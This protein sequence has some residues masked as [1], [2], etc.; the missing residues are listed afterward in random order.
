MSALYFVLMLL[1]ALGAGA[2][3][4]RAA[5]VIGRLARLEV[6]ALSFALGVGVVGWLVFFLALGGHIGPGALSAVLAALALGSALLLPG[7]RRAGTPSP[8]AA[9][10]VPGHDWLR[11]AL[12]LAIAAALGSDLLEA[13]APPVDGDSMAYHF[14]LPK[15]FLAAGKLYPV[16]QA[17][18]GTVPL[19]Q[20]MTYLAALGT[21]GELTMTLWT[22]ATG[23][24]ATAL[25]YVISRRYLSENWSLAAALLF[26]ATPAVIYSAGS[27]QVEVR[28]AMF[29]LAAAFFAAEARRDGDWG[30]A[31]LAGV[32]AG[33]FMASKYPGLIF[34]FACGCMLLLQRRPLAQCAVYTAALMVAGSQWYAWN[35][36]ITGDPV[37][38]VLYGIVDY[39]A[40]V[41][42]NEGIHAVYR[43]AVSEKPLASN[44]FWFFAYPFKATLDPLP[45][46]ESRRVGFGPFAIVVLPF[47]AL[48][49][50]FHR[51]RLLNHPLAV[52]A[53]ACLIAYA[54]WF[55]IGPS[56][57]LRHLLPVY[58]LLLICFAVAA[59]RAA[60]RLPALLPALAGGIAAVI[61]VQMMAVGLYSLNY[62]RYAL[63]GFD[64]EAFLRRNLSEYGA[65]AQASKLLGPGDR[66]LVSTRQ[67]VYQFDVPVFYA[68]QYQQDIVGIHARI[69]EPDR[70]WHQ[71]RRQKI[72]HMLVPY[73]EDSEIPKSPERK[74]AR[75][76]HDLLSQRCLA[77]VTEIAANY[78]TSRTLPG[79]GMQKNRLTL[80]RLTPQTCRYE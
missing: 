62:V 65:V 33:F 16:F 14:A 59:E 63:S 47:A 15:A 37:F 46:F 28:D 41:P 51:D 6:L 11:I 48:G 58:P 24:G 80:V 53:G 27:G 79:L 32:A 55:F 4:L 70:L 56:Q 43:N 78:M 8:V 66:L 25:V 10:P 71:M 50:W 60:R 26:L 72:T 44:L 21:G 75:V 76:F 34:A 22:M 30:N 68:N 69:V 13:L 57:R 1:A 49:A 29:V 73:T 12:W 3:M 35:F 36:W 74:Y 45:I 20:Q 9:G 19:L 31:M 23:W 67:L 5:G 54:V 61:V 17:M 77:V 2:L 52:F 40:G 38:P 42:W 7:L 39:R 64:R 18:E